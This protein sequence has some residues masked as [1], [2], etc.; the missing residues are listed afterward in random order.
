MWI[1]LYTFSSERRKIEQGGGR[2]VKHLGGKT[3]RE[4]S[5]KSASTAAAICV[6]PL[7]GLDPGGNKEVYGV[8]DIIKGKRT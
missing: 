7:L 5:K 8:W 1:E 3:Q 6:C 2:F 4:P